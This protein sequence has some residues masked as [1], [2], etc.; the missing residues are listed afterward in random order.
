MLTEPKLERRDEQPY[1]AIR[2][3]APMGQVGMIV[4]PLI[5][6]VAAWLDERGLTPAGPPFFKYLAVDMESELEIEAGF[7]VAALVRGDDR[8][9][10]GVFPAG[11]YATAVH[12]GHYDD[13]VS[14]TTEFLAWG[15]RNGV[16]WEKSPAQNGETWAS[17]T[18][19]YLTSPEEEP[20]PDRWATELAFLVADDRPS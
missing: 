15:E 13:L 1:V 17:R 4:G 18:E 16:T 19:H 7:P 20:N 3:R 11:R 10:A 6:E 9:R 2:T 8:V 14:A 12:A 5:P